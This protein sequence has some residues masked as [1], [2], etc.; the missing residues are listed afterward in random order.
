MLRLSHMPPNACVFLLSEF[1][2]L[3]QTL[4]TSASSEAISPSDFKMQIQKYAP[5]FVGYK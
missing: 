5:R 2:K 3:T 4:W 1:A